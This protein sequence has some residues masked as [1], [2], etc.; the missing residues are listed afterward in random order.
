MK[1]YQ[2]KE[3]LWKSEQCLKVTNKGDT[4]KNSFGINKK[5]GL[6][7]RSK[8]QKA[9]N[10][11]IKN[12]KLKVKIFENFN[13]RLKRRLNTIIGVNSSQKS[14]SEASTA[15]S[16]V[17]EC[18]SPAVKR[19]ATRRIKLSNTST[20]V[21]K[22]SLTLDWVKSM[23]NHLIWKKNW[24]FFTCWWKLSGSTRHKKNLKRGYIAGFCPCRNCIKNSLLTYRKLSAHLLN[25]VAMS[26]KK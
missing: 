1:I 5:S 2:E 13:R 15:S 25:F 23:Q 19:R 12:I 18:V 24:Q 21:F 7:C 11:K 26:Q 6:K 20:S 14:F 8:Q 22:N 9:K 4:D 10:D 16:V 17:S 3:K